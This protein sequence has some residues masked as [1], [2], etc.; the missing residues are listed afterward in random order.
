MLTWVP[1]DLNFKSNYVFFASSPNSSEILSCSLFLLRCKTNYIIMNYYCSVTALPDSLSCISYSAR[2]C[3]VS[4][5]LSSLWTCS[6]VR[7][8]LLQLVKLQQ[9]K[10][11]IM[12]AVNWIRQTWYNVLFVTVETHHAL[13]TFNW[14][15]KAVI[16]RSC[17]LMTFLDAVHFRFLH[18]T[19]LFYLNISF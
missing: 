6:H 7:L 4:C 16:V 10:P 13:V 15:L 3:D 5:H 9:A 19:L 8:S 11:S 12:I 18:A 14:F 17:S 1:A 2:N